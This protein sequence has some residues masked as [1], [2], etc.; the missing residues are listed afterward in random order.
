VLEAMRSGVVLIAEENGL[1]LGSVRGESRDGACLV[2]RLVV[3]PERQNLGI[4][5]MLA[6]AIEAEFPAAR[7]F[8]IFTGHASERSLHLYESLGYERVREEPVHERLSLV[9]LTKISKVG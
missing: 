7:R 4:G 8:E 1:L 3:E 2:G 6:L 9:F 5:R